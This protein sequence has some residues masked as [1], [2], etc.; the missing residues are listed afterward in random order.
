[1]RPGDT[2]GLIFGDEFAILLEAP[3]RWRSALRRVLSTPFEVDEQEVFV[4]PSIGIAGGE[5]V[6]DQPKEVLR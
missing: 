3:A 6:G 5:T 2:V 1:V 4:S